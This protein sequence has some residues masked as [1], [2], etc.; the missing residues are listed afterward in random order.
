VPRR[1]NAFNRKERKGSA[2]GAES[3]PQAVKKVTGEYLTSQRVRLKIREI[4]A[5]YIPR[6]LQGRNPRIY[7]SNPAAASSREEKQ[8]GRM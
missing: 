2:K 3:G 1:A 7:D 6:P 5:T 4:P 8:Y